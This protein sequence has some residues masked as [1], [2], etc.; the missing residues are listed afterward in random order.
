MVQNPVLPPDV[1]LIARLRSGDEI[2][3]GAMVA[4]WSP[5]LHR[6][7]RSFV[8]SDSLAEEVVQETWMGVVKGL[9]RFEGRSSLKTWVFTILVNRS[10]TRGVRE[11]RTVPMSALGDDEHGPMDPDRFGAGGTWADP[12][13]AWRAQSADAIVETRQA[14]DVLEEALAGLP[15]RQ[16]QVVTLRDIDG[17]EATTVCNLLEISESNQRVLLHRGRSKLRAALE[18]HYASAAAESERPSVDRAR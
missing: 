3:F 2:A 10:R 14:M 13:F 1:E 11:A 4:A 15:T 12:P 16:R 7:A 8:K 17:I 5:S 18:R 6:L 9:A